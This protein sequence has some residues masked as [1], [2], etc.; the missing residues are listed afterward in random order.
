MV[1]VGLK[2]FIQRQLQNRSRNRSLFEYVILATMGLFVGAIIKYPN[3]AFLTRARPDLKD[4]AVKGYPLLGNMPQMLK[5]SDDSLGHLNAA[6]KH[7]GDFFSL[8]IPLFGRVI[9]VNAPE[10]FEHV[11]KTNFSNYIKGSIFRDQLKDI[12]GKGIFVSDQ[13]D[14]RFHRKTAANIFT[15]KLYRQLVSGAFQQT[16]LDLCSV[17][18]RHRISGH[19]VDLQEQFLKLT[20]DAFGKLTFGLE[21][22]ALICEGPNEF[23]DAFDYLTA[24]V[25]TRTSNPFWFLT[26]RI[27]PGKRR[28]LREAIGVLDKFGYMALEKRRAETEQ[29]KEARPRD[30]LDHF[31]NHVADDGAG[32]DTTAQGLSWQFYLL[33]TH[34]RVM[35]NLVREIDT[36]LQDSTSSAY[37]YETMMQELPYL[38]ACFHETLRLYPPVPKNVKMAVDDDVLPGGL[39][40]YKGDV[41]GISSYC[42]GRNKAVWGEDAEQFVPE[43]W[44]VDYGAPAS[45]TGMATTMTEGRAA[46]GVK[47]NASPFGKFKA[48][49]P[50][51]FTSF[52]AGPRLCLGQT[53]ATLEAMVTSCMLLQRYEFRLVPGQPPAT[54]KPSVTIPMT[55]PL[56]TLVS[57]R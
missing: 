8:T 42:L 10:H 21:F 43:R 41:I 26:D 48:E 47:A 22:G 45:P 40:V 44:L 54:P 36:V 11:L 32:R 46:G 7:F 2:R 57:P 31:I 23:G 24:N 28:K 30:L 29:E 39:R 27:I 55:N 56:L 15:T 3:R 12:L 51:K 19:P 25:D 14:W 17:L 6:F 13:E 4:K 49:S 18:D 9:L 1:L 37:T 34:P 33:M 20:L 50:Y 5:N 16:G 52:N 53:F 35:K 38:K